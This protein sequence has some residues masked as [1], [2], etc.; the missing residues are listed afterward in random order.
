MLSDHQTQGY[1]TYQSLIV[2]LLVAACVIVA[3]LEVLAKILRLE[4]E[5]ME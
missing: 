2:V 3:I 4:G 5:K 1:F